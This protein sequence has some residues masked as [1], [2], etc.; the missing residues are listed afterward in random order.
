MKPV[1]ISFYGNFG[2]GN[3]GN[4]CTLQAVIEQT[5]MRWPD[6]QLLC[7]CTNPQDVRTRH[8]IAAFP[9]E[10]FDKA[11][12][13][14][15]STPGGPRDRLPRIFRIAFQR[16]PLELV[17]WIK[18]L[19]EVSRT[20][21]L[22]VAG[23]GIVADYMCGP[24]GWPYDI[25][26]LSTL[27]ALCRVKLVFLSVGVGPIY[28][29]LSRWFLKRSLALANHR[30]YRDEASRQ[31]I[32]KIG[33]NIGHDAVYPDVVF[34]LSRS[35]LVSGLQAGQRRIVGVGLKDYGAI[36]RLERK[37]FREYLDTMA[38]FVAW[39][40]EHGYGV[41]LLIGDVSYDTA[42]IDKFV[43]LLKRQN[44][45]AAAP[46]LIAEPAMTVKELLRQ[47][48]ETE[49]VISPRYHNLVMAF[50]Q[51]KPV[52][53]LSDHAKLDSLVT[54]FGL[55]QYRISLGGLQLDDLINKFRQLQND[56]QQLRPY[57]KARSDEYRRAVAVQYATIFPTLSVNTRIAEGVETAGP[58]IKEPLGADTQ[59]TNSWGG[60]FP[61]HCEG[62]VAG[63]RDAA[64]AVSSATAPQLLL[65]R[66]RPEEPAE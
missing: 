53:A 40:Q 55:A 56:A 38:A 60:G 42:V 45:P 24:L 1:R 48:G 11:A 31:Y 28:H 18:S 17:H 57:I 7:F 61:C 50:L 27:A 23:T 25:F 65:V 19:H 26:K 16:I 39:L 21:M 30:S 49:V 59:L 36:K 52:I 41:R 62:E 37:A 58:A 47:V 66:P 51:S 54:D 32:E 3:L 22:I 5:R 33:F 46:L 4:E 10:A 20:D 13:A 14:A 6:A 8:N 64:D 63:R 35:N 34:G 15:R 29:P 43:S 9:S 12:A 44:I 2:A